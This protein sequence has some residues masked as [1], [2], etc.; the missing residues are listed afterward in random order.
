M[1]SEVLDLVAAYENGFANYLRN[2]FLMLNRK[3][4]LSEGHLLFNEF[5]ETMQAFVSP[6]RE[7]ARSLMASRDLVF[8]GSPRKIK[9]LH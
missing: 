5:E 6:L 7:K 8:R 9:R 3:L 4:T 1:Y 2:K